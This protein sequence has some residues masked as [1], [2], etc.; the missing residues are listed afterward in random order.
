MGHVMRL[1]AVLAALMVALAAPAAAQESTPRANAAEQQTTVGETEVSWSGA[2]ELEEDAST[3]EIVSLTI[4]DEERLQVRL[5]TYAEM[6]DETVDGPE[7]A[8]GAFADAF[9]SDPGVG[10]AVEVESGELEDGTA[11]A[12]YT[13]DLDGVAV[14]TLFAV[15]ESED[16]LFMVSSVTANVTDFAEVVAI[17]QEQI[18]L[19]GE[20][21]FLAGIDAAVIAPA[22]QASPESTPAG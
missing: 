20:P 5:A 10:N 8:L 4:P 18:L 15:N 7:E 17:A 14:A 19:D 11:W 13:Y 6:V 9:L 1:G 2:W 22:P 3:D 12:M 16:G 21:A